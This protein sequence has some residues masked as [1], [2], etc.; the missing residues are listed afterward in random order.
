MVKHRTVRLAIA[1]TDMIALISTEVICHLQVVFRDKDEQSLQGEQTNGSTSIVRVGQEI[2]EDCG[3]RQVWN[4]ALMYDQESLFVDDGRERQS[5]DSNPAIREHAL[6]VEQSQQ[7]VA[8][9]MS[10]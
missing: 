7:W 1:F 4:D 2:H 3:L 10:G 5:Q 9:D 8:L 6:V